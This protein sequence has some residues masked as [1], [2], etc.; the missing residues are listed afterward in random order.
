MSLSRK[1]FLLFS[2]NTMK[3]KPFKLNQLCSVMLLM[4]VPQV[5]FGQEIG[6]RSGYELAEKKQVSNS[7]GSG[8]YVMHDN[9]SEKMHLMIALDY[10]RK[11]KKFLENDL[12][13]SFSKYRF[14][15]GVLFAESLNKIL[16]L[17]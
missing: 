5:F 7:F 17:K 2:K 13:T 6:I 9:F 16:V 10:F 15:T 8:F 4:L 11:D 3:V 12:R 1:Y 14:S